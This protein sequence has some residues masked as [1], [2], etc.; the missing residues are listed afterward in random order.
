MPCIGGPSWEDEKAEAAR[1]KAEAKK[2]ERME[3]MNITLDDYVAGRV[4]DL[5]LIKF[6]CEC[7]SN[8]RNG[9]TC[10]AD[11]DGNRYCLGHLM[12]DDQVS[13][14]SVGDDIRE[15]VTKLYGSI[16]PERLNTLV[17]LERLYDENDHDDTLI[18]YDRLIDRLSL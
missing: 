17:L 13:V 11:E 4:S 9:W 18:E 15:I 8:Q 3:V 6:V 10:Y 2:Q 16:H 7:V 12:T 1:A 5:D 14:A